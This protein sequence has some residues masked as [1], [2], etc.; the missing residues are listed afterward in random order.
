MPALASIV[1]GGLFPLLVAC[2]LGFI[3]FRQTPMPFVV[4]FGIGAAIESL[5]VFLLR[6]P[7]PMVPEFTREALRHIEKVAANGAL[8]QP[9]PLDHVG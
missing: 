8:S 9:D 4:R 7:D 2:A 6:H 5:L 1:F 3:A